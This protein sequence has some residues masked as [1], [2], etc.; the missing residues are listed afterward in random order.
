MPIRVRQRPSLGRPGG[1]PK[2]YVRGFTLIELLVV[3]ALI[4]IAT[5]TLSLALRD[6]AGAQLEREAERLAALF[7]TARAE[8]RAAGL[9]V[10]WAPVNDDSGDQFRFRGL[11]E[12][13]QLP[14]RWLG[15][16]VAVEIVGARSV[17]LG[18]EPMVGAQRL[19]LSLGAQRIALVTD[20]LGPFEPQHEPETAP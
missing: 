3:V 15:E 9:T 11:P 16:A 17:Q 13:M 7:E 20:G 2:R 14:R 8:A 6:P 5:A 10:Q 18:P 19:R 12:R 1:R 4:A